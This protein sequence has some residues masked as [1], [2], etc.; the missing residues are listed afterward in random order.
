MKMINFSGMHGGFS[1]FLRQFLYLI[2]KGMILPIPQ[3]ILKGKKWIVGSSNIGC[4]LGSYEFENQK[5]FER[6]IKKDHVVYDI[7]AHVGFF[8]LF[9]EQ[10]GGRVYAFEPL[11]RNYY[12]LLKHRQLNNGT[13][14][15]IRAAISDKNGVGK[16]SD[17]FNSHSQ[18]R[19]AHE[20]EEV[21][22][23][24]VD[25]LI[26][27]GLP[28]PDFIKIDVEGNTLNVLKGMTKL[29]NRG[30]KILCEGDEEDKKYLISM[31]YSIEKTGNVSDFFAVKS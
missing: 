18:A 16:I 6:H 27:M 19:L 10:L 11:S 1:R 30:T 12:Y 26:E 5:F 7:G 24:S 4:W 28:R 14:F 29:L 2:P 3:G 17:D 22:I 13:F 8:S 20:G 21:V 25:G 23:F 9:S 15:H 31:G